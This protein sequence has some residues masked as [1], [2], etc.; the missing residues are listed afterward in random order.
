M[1]PTANL[2]EWHKTAGIKTRDA[3][4]RARCGVPMR[5]LYVRE[6]LPPCGGAAASRSWRIAQRIDHPDNNIAAEFINEDIANEVDILLLEWSGAVR[7]PG[8]PCAD[9][10]GVSIACADDV[11]ALIDDKHVTALALNAG[12]FSLPAA[13]VLLAFQKNM[14]LELGID[15]VGALASG[16][17]FPVENEIEYMCDAAIHVAQHHPDAKTVVVKTAP[18]HLAGAS[19]VHELAVAIATGKEYIEALL[20]TGL[21]IDDACR[22]VVFTFS[23][24][25]DFF[26]Q[27][28]KL[29]AARILWNRV[30]EAFGAPQESRVMHLNAESAHRFLA[31]RDSWTNIVRI[32][33]A[34]CAAGI[35][36]VDALA[37]HPF[38]HALGVAD[39]D[40]RRIARNIHFLLREEA[41]LGEGTDIAAGTWSVEALTYD[42]AQAAW[43]MFQEICNLG[44][45]TEVLRSGWLAERIRE[46]REWRD[47]QIATGKARIVGIN[48]HPYL[49]ETPV[50]VCPVDV[51]TRRS[52]DARVLDGFETG[53]SKLQAGEGRGF[54]RLIE[55]ASGG[56]RMGELAG[57][58][59]GG[60]QEDCSP[61]PQMRESEP[62]E[63]LRD[64]GVSF[65][66]KH[67]ALPGVFILEN[68]T[69]SRAHRAYVE[70]VLN[71]AGLRV[72]GEGSL[73]H[74]KKS[75]AHFSAAL[76]N[77][78]VQLLSKDGSLSLAF[79]SQS[80]LPKIFSNLYE[81]LD[82]L[83]A[84][85]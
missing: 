69:E 8:L 79:D 78:S 62:W 41:M 16:S 37:L 46:Q 66:A 60:R 54:A 3:P 73:D 52:A 38:T 2:K 74:F 59:G 72:A 5:S 75:G 32:A 64:K 13:A 29:R 55:H 10:N 65:E 58:L 82:K 56:A 76:E 33:T 17:I 25:T 28:S 26:P 20:N 39:K 7:Q 36:G 11:S 47:E 61:L 22:Q 40:A 70:D 18:Y 83:E 80:N 12:A 19:D 14:K 31:K 23:A 63:S 24:D 43:E 21:G 48:A 50:S 77:E 67:G 57:L 27:I 44:G 6:D 4:H 34:G 15:P 45:M 1:K 53:E 71:C 85:P 81:N 68:G 9:V 84:R 49:E 30:T 51:E 42:M 35:A